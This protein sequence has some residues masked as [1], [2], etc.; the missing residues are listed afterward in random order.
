LHSVKIAVGFVNVSKHDVSDDD[1]RFCRENEKCHF[2]QLLAI[3][4][5]DNFRKTCPSVGPVLTAVYGVARVWWWW[6]II[7]TA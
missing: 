5:P 6:M 7:R 2:W 4:S 3:S 1:I